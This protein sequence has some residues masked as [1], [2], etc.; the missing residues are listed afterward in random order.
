MDKKSSKN[1]DNSERIA[2]LLENRQL[3]LPSP[4]TNTLTKCSKL[5]SFVSKEIGENALV[6][7]LCGAIVVGKDEVKK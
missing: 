2:K 7:G 6:G 4:I 5:D 1:L 3:I